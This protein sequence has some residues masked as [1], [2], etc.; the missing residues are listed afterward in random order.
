MRKTH[1]HPILLFPSI[2]HDKQGPMNKGR[3][4]KRICSHSLRH[5]FVSH[6]LDQGMDICSLQIRLCHNG[7]NTTAEYT[8]REQ[9]YG[10]LLNQDIRRSIADM[11]QYK[12]AGNRSIH[13]QSG[14]CQ[15]GHCQ[16][17]EK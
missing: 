12:I 16:H 2:H 6:L 7:L 8:Q 14:H 1:H 17:Q 15:S 13:W 5:C 9:R 11:I 10:R 3:I 4:H